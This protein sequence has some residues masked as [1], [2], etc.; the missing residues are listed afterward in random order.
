M[1]CNVAEQICHSTNISR[2]LYIFMEGL[3]ILVY[4]VE[5]FIYGKT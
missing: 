5:S 2:I 4:N 3:L 1:I